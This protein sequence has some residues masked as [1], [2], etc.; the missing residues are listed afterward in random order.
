MV[1]FVDKARGLSRNPLGIIALFIAFIHGFATL[2]LGVAAGRLLCGERMPLVWFVV[3]FPVLVLGVFYLLVTR[4]NEKLY[5]PRDYRTDKSFQ[6]ASFLT[7]LTPAQK[8]SRANEELV[9][10]HT[11]VVQPSSVLEVSG[12]TAVARTTHD[13][14]SVIPP[15][16]NPDELRA[17]LNLAERLGLKKIQKDRGLEIKNQVAFGNDASSAFDGVAQTGTSFVAIEVKLLRGSWTRPVTIR[18]VLYRAMVA[19]HM[20]QQR[21][22]DRAEFRLLLVFVVEKGDVERGRLGR[23]IEPTLK[24]APIAIEWEIYGLADLEKEFPDVTAE[25]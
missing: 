23:L 1:S 9:S 4:H 10:I 5:A 2:L 8:E 18:E 15:L 16:S 7:R 12:D 19:N 3:L 6:D 22:G 21:F 11:D 14:T 20:V 24:E 17:R 13:S 25:T